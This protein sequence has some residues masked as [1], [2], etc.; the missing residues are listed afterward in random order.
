M[1]FNFLYLFS[2][3]GYFNF[4]FYSKGKPVSPGPNPPNLL[5]QQWS[6]LPGVLFDSSP[7]GKKFGDVKTDAEPSYQ[8]VSCLCI[9]LVFGEI[10]HLF[11]PIPFLIP[12]TST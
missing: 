3:Q 2:I 7:V 8:P 10:F 5:G 4:I 9:L 6:F 12:S 1:N 11:S